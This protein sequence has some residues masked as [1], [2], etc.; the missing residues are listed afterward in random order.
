MTFRYDT[1]IRLDVYGEIVMLEQLAYLA[2][3]V[4]VI[5]VIASLVYVALQLRQ[6]TEAQLAASRQ[7]TMTADIGLLSKCMDYPDAVDGLG[8]SADDVRFNAYL[9][10]YL[11]IREFAWYQY[12][13]GILDQTTWESYMAPTGLVFA[14]ERA[15]RVWNSNVIRLD[16]GFRAYVDKSI[17]TRTGA[18]SV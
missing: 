18:P 5:M 8:E 16:S 6:N 14:S 7:V 1:L 10:M 11:R 3:I 12:Q 17:G 4:G 15:R 13:N 2:E 9:V